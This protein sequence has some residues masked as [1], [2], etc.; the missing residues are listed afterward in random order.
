VVEFVVSHCLLDGEGEDEHEG[1]EQVDWDSGEEAVEPR[2]SI[3]KPRR[4]RPDVE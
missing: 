2:W 4:V 1:D 3:M